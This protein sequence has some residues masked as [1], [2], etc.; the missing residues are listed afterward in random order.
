MGELVSSTWRVVSQMLTYTA[1]HINYGGRV[2]DDWDRRCLLCL[3]A[4]YYAPSVLSD[5]H[6]F[7]DTA[8]YKQVHPLSPTVTTSS[9]PTL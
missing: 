2:T 6:A 3:L 4:D 5:R 9:Y 7:D 1:G 8:A